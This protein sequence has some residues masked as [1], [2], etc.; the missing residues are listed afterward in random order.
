MLNRKKNIKSVIGVSLK[1][2]FHGRT[3]EPALWT[4]ST[5]ESYEKHN[6]KRI[7]DNKAE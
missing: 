5:R 4:D 6:V 7:L 1:D 2:S 3:F